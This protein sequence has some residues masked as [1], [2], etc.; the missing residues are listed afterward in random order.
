MMGKKGVG[1]KTKTKQRGDWKGDQR[2]GKGDGWAK[3]FKEW[4]G[5]I[6]E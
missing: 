2:G 3:R 5:I 4:G 1:N 6:D